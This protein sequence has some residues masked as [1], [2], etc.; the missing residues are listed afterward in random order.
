MLR[1]VV[2]RFVVAASFWFCSSQ[3]LGADQVSLRFDITAYR[4]EGST[5]L[6]NKQ[7]QSAVAPFQ[8]KQRDFADIQRALEALETVYRKAGFGAVQIFLPEQE[9]QGGVVVLRVVES[10]IGKVEVTGNKHFDTGNIRRSVPA[11]KE[12]QTPN[13]RALADNLRAANESPVKQARVVLRPSSQPNEVDAKVEVEDES[14]WR[15]FSTLDNTGTDQTGS[16]RLGVGLQNANLFNRDHVAH[17]AIH[18]L[19]RGAGPSLH[20]QP[21][22]SPAAVWPGRQH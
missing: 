2:A 12:G 5:L 8:G 6:T 15:V 16:T 21:G 14:P 3:I 18:H 11:L 19:A 4:V 10:R 22:L 1:G 13:S 20:L 7:L 9:L 17:R